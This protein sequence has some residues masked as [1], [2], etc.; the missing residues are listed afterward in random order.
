M[1]CIFVP[2]VDVH[3]SVLDHQVAIRC[4]AVAYTLSVDLWTQH[5]ESASCTV[6]ALVAGRQDCQPRPDSQRQPLQLLPAL[7]FSAST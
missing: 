3:P 6:N 7:D 5:L 2:Y 1:K 4:L